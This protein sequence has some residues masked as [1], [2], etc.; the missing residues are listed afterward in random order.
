M[1]YEKFFFFFFSP[2]FRNLHKSFITSLIKY[3]E[4]GVARFQWQRHGISF[5]EKAVQS[6]DPVI[7]YTYYM[8]LYV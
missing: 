1:I 5:E 8:Y 7:D 2:S 6:F 4:N 3:V